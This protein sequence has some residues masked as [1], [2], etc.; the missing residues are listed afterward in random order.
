MS[1]CG[2]GE[3]REAPLVGSVGATG[4]ELGEGAGG[5][6]EDDVVTAAARLVAERLGEVALADAGGPD[7]E[8][9]L[10]RAR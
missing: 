9:V 3:A 10:V 4:G 7:E 2:P 5:R 1:R 8:D 6:H